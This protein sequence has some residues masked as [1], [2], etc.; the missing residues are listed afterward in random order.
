MYEEYAIFVYFRE[1]LVS[2]LELNVEL[3]IGSYAVTIYFRG[4][5][6]CDTIYKPIMYIVGSKLYV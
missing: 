6:F 4:L 5:L 1:V 3:K 2:G